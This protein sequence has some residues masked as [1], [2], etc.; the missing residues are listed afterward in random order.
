MSSV[1]SRRRH[2]TLHST[3]NP[4]FDEEDLLGFKNPNAESL[5]TI[6]MPATAVTTGIRGGARSYSDVEHEM[7]PIFMP[8]EAVDH[9][10]RKTV[11]MEQRVDLPNRDDGPP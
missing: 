3:T 1:G 11:K 6:S 5:A 2:T 4:D 8:V 7:D 9:S 10:I